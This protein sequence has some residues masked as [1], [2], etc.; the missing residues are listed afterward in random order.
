[1]FISQMPCACDFCQ[2]L[3]EYSDQSHSKLILRKGWSESN[4]ITLDRCSQYL[5][6]MTSN[7]WQMRYLFKK[8]RMKS[9]GMFH[10]SYMQWQ[11]TARLNIIC[12]K[13]IVSVFFHLKDTIDYPKSIY[14]VFVAMGQLSPWILRSFLYLAWVEYSSMLT[15]FSIDRSIISLL[16]FSHRD[17]FAVLEYLMDYHIKKT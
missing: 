5:E 15:A 17:P 16:W 2:G 14:L 10:I 12:S 8:P 6:A 4:H 3:P 13:N 1:M 11:V 7:G 9:D